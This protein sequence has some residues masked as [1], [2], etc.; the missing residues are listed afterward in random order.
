MLWGFVFA[1]TDFID[2]LTDPGMLAFA[3]QSYKPY[4][5]YLQ[6]FQKLQKRALKVLAK[7]WAT[8]DAKAVRL[9][10]FLR[11]R[12]LA[13]E[14]PFPFVGSVLKECYLTCVPYGGS[15]VA[16]AVVCSPH[17]I[18]SLSPVLSGTRSSCPRPTRPRFS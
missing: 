16:S 2:Q 18:S 6:P 3:L 12:Q 13:V 9:Q 5:V 14:I 11:L 7:M 1:H 4:V 15:G 17:T 8:T 10:A